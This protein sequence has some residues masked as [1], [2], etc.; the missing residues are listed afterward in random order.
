MSTDSELTAMKQSL[1]QLVGEADTMKRYAGFVEGVE[2]D[3]ALDTKTT[4]L[5]ALAIGAATP[6]DGCVQ[7]HLDA[8]LEAGATREEIIETLEVATMM[9][10][11]PA[12]TSAIEAYQM[13]DDAGDD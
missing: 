9:G 4:E 13:L 7:W 2:S 5:M 8:A 6:C 10:G 1:Q 3:G 12:M 11:G